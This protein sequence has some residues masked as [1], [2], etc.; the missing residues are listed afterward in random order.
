MPRNYKEEYRKYQSGTKNIKKRSKLNKINRDKGTYGNGDGKDVSH[1]S[2]GS[3]VLED[4]SKNRGNGTRTPGDRRARGKKGFKANKGYKLN[5]LKKKIKFDDG[6]EPI[7]KDDT[8]VIPD[9]FHA[10]MDDPLTEG[11]IKEF[12]KLFKEDEFKMA[13]GEATPMSLLDLI[14]TKAGSILGT[15]LLRFFNKTLGKTRS[16]FRGIGKEGF[17]DLKK[18]GAFRPKQANPNKIVP[19]GT[20]DL[21]RTGSFGDLTYV[22]PKFN[23]AKQ[24]TTGKGYP[25]YLAEFEDLHKIKKIRRKMGDRGK[26][27]QTFKGDLPI[28]QSNARIIKY[29][30]PDDKFG[31]TVADFRKPLIGK[32]PIPTTPIVN[33]KGDKK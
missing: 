14:P 3:I 30:G 29:T 8:T 33:K 12:K 15:K 4:Q 7:V 26:W 5:K 16:Y 11:E 2:D 32:L 31:T 10:N 6:G 13:T 20:F 17:D 28:K 27:S 19:S 21:D 9:T 24:Y 25:A 18:Y 1:M 22:S 23:A